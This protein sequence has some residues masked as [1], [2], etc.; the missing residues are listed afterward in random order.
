MPLDRA[1]IK[2]KIKIK[3]QEMEVLEANNEADNLDKYVEIFLIL[4][5][6]LKNNA[7]VTGVCSGNGGP[8]ANGKIT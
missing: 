5:D 8:L 6:E 3:L 7:V 2:E 1:T 4:L